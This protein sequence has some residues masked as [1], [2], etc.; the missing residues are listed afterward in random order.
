MPRLHVVVSRMVLGGHARTAAWTAAGVLFL[1]GVA[2]GCGDG[3]GG[4]GEPSPT[5]SSPSVTRG[6]SGP[7]DPR[8]AEQQ[9]RTAWQKFFDPAT[10]VEEKTKL[11]QNGEQLQPLLQ[12][13][14]GDQRGRQVAAKVNKVTFTSPTSADVTYDLTLQGATALPNASGTAV[15]EGGTW[16]VSVK[17]L[18]ALVSMSGNEVRV[19]GC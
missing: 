18:C 1:G 17:S 5:T 11:L 6:T 12:A 3:G 8:A 14:S 15:Q 2:A 13:F 9:I 7:A 10:P 4:N 19:P 16:K